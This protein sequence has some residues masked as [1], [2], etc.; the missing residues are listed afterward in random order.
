MWLSLRLP[1]NEYDNIIRDR[2]KKAVY[3][4]GYAANLLH[5]K[6][7]GQLLS[8]GQVEIAID[9]LKDNMSDDAMSELRAYLSHVENMERVL[10][11]CENPISFWTLLE[12]RF[13]NLSKFAIK[14]FILPG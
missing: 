6:Y 2:I 8:D 13:K 12:S 11:N 4:V 10:D 9:F 1:T 7:K 5:P 14:F 3:P